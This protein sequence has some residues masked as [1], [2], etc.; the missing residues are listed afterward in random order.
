MSTIRMSER[1]LIGRVMSLRAIRSFEVHA[2]KKIIF[3]LSFENLKIESFR[4]P[5]KLKSFV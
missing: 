3:E 1:L 2:E 5:Q 4:K